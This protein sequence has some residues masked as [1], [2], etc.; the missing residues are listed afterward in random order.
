M[1]E[2]GFINFLSV[3]LVFHARGTRPCPIFT[4]FLFVTIFV[5]LSIYI[6]ISFSIYSSP[7]CFIPSLFSFTFYICIC[8]QPC[9]NLFPITQPNFHTKKF[10]LISIYHA[11]FTRNITSFTHSLTFHKYPYFHFNNRRCRET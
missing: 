11:I 2:F 9:I 6:L 3:K 5:S 8:T 4:F 10:K 1:R 7:L